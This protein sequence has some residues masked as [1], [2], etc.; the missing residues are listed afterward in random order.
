MTAAQEKKKHTH[1]KRKAALYQLL[2]KKKSGNAIV[3][4]LR[5]VEEGQNKAV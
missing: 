2:G 3:K 5:R 1:M 4:A